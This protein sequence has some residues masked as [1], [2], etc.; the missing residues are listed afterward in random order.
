MLQCLRVVVM[1]NM[2]LGAMYWLVYE[3]E[4]EDGRKT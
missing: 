3:E 4:E 2:R 1:N